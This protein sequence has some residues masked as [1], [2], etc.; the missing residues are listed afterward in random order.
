MDGAGPAKSHQSEFTWIP[1]PLGGHGPQ[2][3]H[4]AGIGNA[5]DAFGRLQQIQSEGRGNAV[6]YR[7]LCSLHVDRYL[8]VGQVSGA[9]I[10]QHHIGV[11]ER[12]FDSSPLIAGRPRHGSGAARPHPQTAGLVQKGDATTS[13]PHFGDVD[14]GC[15]DQLAP[16]ADEPV[17]RG[18]RGTHLVL[19]A[20]GDAALFDHGRLGRGAAHIEGDDLVQS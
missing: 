13:C 8:A 5:V 2:G 16:A 1:P 18:Q 12:R 15:P 19:G 3:P 20:V 14:A 6:V 7:P 11:G 9:D 4:G 17:A 10:A